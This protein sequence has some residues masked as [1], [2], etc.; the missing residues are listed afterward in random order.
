MSVTTTKPLPDRAAA[1]GAALA[2]L[3][4]FRALQRATVAAE[5][6]AI[7]GVL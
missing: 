7:R 5:V 3:A 2:D 1:Y 6:A 4:R